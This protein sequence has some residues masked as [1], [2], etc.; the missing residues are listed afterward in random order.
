MAR[1]GLNFHA[2][3]KQTILN[4]VVAHEVQALGTPLDPQK[5]INAVLPLT[6]GRATGN[7]LDVLTAVM[8]A[9]TCWSFW[10]GCRN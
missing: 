1:N 3:Q 2:G 4:A 6:P 8:R 7:S 5:V 9:A 10:P